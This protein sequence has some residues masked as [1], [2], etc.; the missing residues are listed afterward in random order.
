MMAA[1]PLVET[2]EAADAAIIKAVASFSV[3]RR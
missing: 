3:L 1:M 2:H